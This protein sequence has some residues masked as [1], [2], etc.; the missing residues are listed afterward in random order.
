MKK[1]LSV[2]DL[3]NSEDRVYIYIDGKLFKDGSS[4][5]EADIFQLCSDFQPFAYYHHEMIENHWDDQEWT[6]TP[7]NF[8]DM[9]KFLKI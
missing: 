7:N 5:P 1:E 4:F 3:C 6:E 9:T 2:I 8:S